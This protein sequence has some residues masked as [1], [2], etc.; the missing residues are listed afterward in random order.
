LIVVFIFGSVFGGVL[1]DGHWRFAMLLVPA[2][3]AVCFLLT[4]MIL[5]AMPK[6]PGGKPDYLGMTTIALAMIAFL[7]GIAQVSHGL[8][9]PQFYI[10]TVLGLV[11]FAVYYWIETKV[12]NP[13]F[14]PR[15][16]ASGIFGA[17]IVAGIAWNFAQGAVQLQTSNFWQY[18]QHYSTSEVAAG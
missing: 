11:L 12:E 17:A 9:A 18:V 6:V 16:F 10:P 8:H 4:P 13:I 3:A 2:I 14:P 1:A 7:Y 5:P 15:L